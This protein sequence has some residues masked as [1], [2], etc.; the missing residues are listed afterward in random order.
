[1]P[2]SPRSCGYF[3]LIEC[4]VETCL[5]P[6]G[7]Y[8]DMMLVTWIVN[9]GSIY[10]D[11]T[12]AVI[13]GVLLAR[14][15]V[16]KGSLSPSGG[17][18]A[19]AVA[20]LSWGSGVRFGATMIAFYQSSSWLT[21]LGAKRKMRLDA[22]NSEHG[23]RDALQVLSCSLVA[24]IVAVFHRATCGREGS[25]PRLTAAFVGFFACC[26]GDTWASE[27]GQLAKSSPRL[28]TAP[29]R[30][31]PPG[32][33][34]GVTVVG[35]MASAAGGL[36]IGVFHGLWLWRDL[37]MLTLL[38]LLTGFLGSTLDSILGATLQNS[39]YNDK[40]KC[41]VTARDSSSRV[42][43]GYDVLS[44]HAV[45]FVSAAIM[46]ALAPSLA[47]FLNWQL[48]RSSDYAGANK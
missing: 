4:G 39:R 36:Y 8:R 34:G 10:V 15:G 32:T 13:I 9:P 35:I 28:I 43:C 6:G 24:S 48:R 40:L 38:G 22:N 29:W 14:R 26:A 31:V 2:S 41:I 33:N 16:Q 17:L 20:V 21:R 47:T 11:V 19:L 3:L 12:C 45:N 37:K 27:I 44:N 46:T 18:A 5:T 23:N 30:L 25:C 1:M 42:I 7:Q